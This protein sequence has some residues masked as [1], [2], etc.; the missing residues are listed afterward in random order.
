MFKTVVELRSFTK[1]MVVLAVILRTCLF[2]F[3]VDRWILIAVAAV[4]E[5]LRGGRERGLSLWKSSVQ[6]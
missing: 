4:H 5:D 3:A 2:L 6:I 1:M